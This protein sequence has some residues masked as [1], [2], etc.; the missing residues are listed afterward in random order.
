MK[1]SNVLRFLCRL[2]STKCKMSSQKLF[3]VRFQKHTIETYNSW[4][5]IP[6]VFNPGIEK[7]LM[8][9]ERQEKRDTDT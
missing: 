8:H 6:K 1:K 7:I 3:S 2:D 4:C 5:N 9:R